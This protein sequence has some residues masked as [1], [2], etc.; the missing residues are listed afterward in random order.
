MKKLALLLAFVLAPIVLAAQGPEKFVGPSSQ[1]LYQLFVEYWEWRLA[2]QPELATRF[3]RVDHNDRWRDWSKTARERMRR[4]REEFLQKAIYLEPGNLNA[5]DRLSAR[6]MISELQTQLEAEPYLELVQRTSQSDGAHNDVFGT[7]D[8]MPSRTVKDYENII[9]RLRALPAYVDRTIDLMREQLAAGLAQ[10]AIVIDLTLDQIVAQR[11]AS[12]DQSPLLNAFKRF[13]G[14][15]SPADQGRLRSDARKAYEQQFVASW[16]KLETFLRETYRPHARTGIGL[17]SLKNGRAAYAGLIHAYT[18]TRMEP[19]RIHQLGLDEVARIEKEMARLAREAGFTGSVTDYEKQLGAQPGM[20]FTGQEEML[21]YARDVLARVQPALPRLFIRVPKMTVGVRPIPAD[22]EA[23]TASNYTVGTAD[24]SRPAWFNM[25][26]YRPQDQFKY[27]IPALVLHESVPGHH[28]Q[29]GL[30]RE[31]PGLPDFRRAYGASAFSEG[32]A[33]YAE[34]LGQEIGAY[35]DLST[36][37]GQLA[38]EQFRAVRLV[39]DTGIHAMGW[40]R[41]RARE[42]FAL[43]APA[44]SLAEVDRYIARPG[45]ALAYKLGQLKIVELR[46]RAE[47]KLGAKFDIREFHDVVLRNGTLP[48]DLLEDEVDAYITSKTR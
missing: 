44:Q 11:E 46:H 27:T 21:Q 18:T 35:T 14:D 25:N 6:L 2:Q 34:S 17:G 12:P 4:D 38:S 28:L 29:I 45:Q 32:W 10:P 26:T 42:Y 48:L 47:Q 33:L 13:P 1:T 40:S 41:D 19:E 9:T 22:R 39:V 37:F 5:A 24:G 31:L 8:A 43:H 16:T 23:S 3:G 20:R 15:I 7:I 36:R 30:A